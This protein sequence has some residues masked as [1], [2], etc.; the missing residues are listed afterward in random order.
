M[1]DTPIEGSASIDFI[2]IVVEGYELDIL[3]GAVDTITKYK[4][5][6]FVEDKNME[7]EDIAELM[8]DMNYKIAED[9]LTSY[10]WIYDE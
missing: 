6:I 2:K 8:K 5:T 10:I 4:P 9:D 1:L 3:E 7:S